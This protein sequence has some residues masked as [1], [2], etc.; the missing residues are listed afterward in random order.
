MYNTKE[1]SRIM[2]MIKATDQLKKARL[3]QTCWRMIRRAC[4][5]ML[6]PR[7]SGGMPPQKK[8]QK[9]VYLN[10]VLAVK[11]TNKSALSSTTTT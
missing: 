4:F 10:L 3:K 11:L 8:F 6:L 2:T 9:I 7:G 1:R 5:S